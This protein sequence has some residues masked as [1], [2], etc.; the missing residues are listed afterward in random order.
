MRSI[1]DAPD[2]AAGAPALCQTKI[3]CTLPD[4][5][6]RLLFTCKAITVTEY[7]STVS[8]QVGT[9]LRYH[10]LLTACWERSQSS[11]RIRYAFRYAALP[12]L[13]RR[14]PSLRLSLTCCELA[15]RAGAQAA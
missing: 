8:C 5:I 10:D 4:L 1:V 7:H 6:V 2:A 12:L 13:L 9:S 14:R 15:Y 3:V 11:V